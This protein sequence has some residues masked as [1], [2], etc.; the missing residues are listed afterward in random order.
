MADKWPLANGNWSNAANWNGGTKPV[1]GDDV[2][3][4]NRTVTVDENV[5]I[6]TG[7]LRNSARSG[8]TAGGTFNAN[9]GISIT[10]N[11]IGSTV[12]SC[13]IAPASGTLVL[14]G[15]VT[16]GTSASIIGFSIPTGSTT[17]VTVTGN[18]TS[19]GAGDGIQHNGNGVLTVTGNPTGGTG[20]GGDGIAINPSGGSGTLNLVGNCTGGSAE[21]S[22]VV[23][24]GNSTVNI[25]GTIYGGLG[26]N[27]YGVSGTVNSVVNIT[28]DV[29][30]STT[31]LQGS[32]GVGLNGASTITIN[33]NV[34]GGGTPATNV[35]VRING[36][37]GSITINGDVIG[38]H[39]PGLLSVINTTGNGFINGTCIGSVVSSGAGVSHAGLGTIRIK[40]AKGNGFGIGSVGLIAGFAVINNGVGISEIEEL[41]FG[42]LG[43]SP[44]SG[45]C[46]IRDLS[47]NVCLMQRSSMTKKTLVDPST[48]GDYPTNANVR[49]GTQFNFGN[50][51]GTL[52]V[53][54]PNQVAAGIATDNTVGTA[55]I[56]E[57][58]LLPFLQQAL[59]PNSPIAVER[60]IDDEKSITFSWPV[61]GATI[62]GEKSVD[63]GTY[64]AVA[65]GISFLRTESGRHYYTLAYNAAD[66]VNEES[67]IRYKMTDGTYTRY[68]NLRLVPP[69]ITPQQIESQL[70]DDFNTVNANVAAVGLA[71]I[72]RPTLSQIEASTVL[73]KEASATAN[74]TEILTAI[75]NIEVDNAAIASAVRVEL[76]DELEIINN[77][78]ASFDFISEQID[79][80]QTVVYVSPAYITV[81]M[82]I[83]AK[84]IRPFYKD[85]SRLGP[86]GYF[87]STKTPINLSTFDG[88]M[89]LVVEDKETSTVLLYDEDPTYVE[90]NLYIDPSQESV[91][92]SSNN[93][94]W[95]LRLISNDK[96]LM[97]GPWEIQNAAYGTS[98]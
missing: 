83:K 40:R 36:N 23:A 86:I 35:G 24:A 14:N 12:G 80:I 72:D 92:S 31:A 49:L 82:S 51:T 41:E 45:P 96:V 67:T 53:P 5:D 15:N 85:T 55:V 6:G 56:T 61:S 64:S 57:A 25:V 43:M 93:I 2:Y 95:A 60:S 76:T 63:N 52:A 78:P 44:V 11:V 21:N 17:N 8:G 1:A 81:P 71:V 94:C 69:G 34:T 62:S 65:G 27:S 98:P 3:A 16:G 89:Y 42:D 84:T 20:N 38:R 97:E 75:G 48:V 70:E 30:G 33:G 13:L 26:N 39:A 9:S 19:L 4:D 32:T 87:D 22:G 91:E 18:Q 54:N 10:A 58:S 73:A 79:G 59:S 68:F 50:N 88:N 66:R 46:Y 74:K 47:T 90:H 37:G 7:T 77:I 29:I 28:G